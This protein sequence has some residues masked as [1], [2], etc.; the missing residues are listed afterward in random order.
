MLLTS[1]SEIFCFFLGALSSM[2][3]VKV[4]S[5]Y[6]GMAIAFDFFLQVT[7]FLALFV[8][9]VR[10]QEVRRALRKAY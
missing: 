4:F 10:R 5:L 7:C 8:L 6:A 1:L 9:D 3:A 2:P